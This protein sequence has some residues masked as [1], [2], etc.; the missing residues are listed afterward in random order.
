MSTGKYSP[1][2]PHANTPGWDMFKYNCYGEVPA[3]SHEVADSDVTYD[4][5]AMFGDY[6]A[7]DK[8]VNDYAGGNVDDA[9]EQ[10][11]HAGEVMLARDILH[12]MGIS[13][14]E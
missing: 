1:L 5:K 13:W 2:C 7:E 10:G 11:E 12:H 6:D 3:G 8:C 14:C 9:F 4:E